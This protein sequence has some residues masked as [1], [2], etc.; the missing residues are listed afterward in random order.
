MF[1]FFRLQVFL[2]SSRFCFYGARTDFGW[3]WKS[4]DWEKQKE[5]AQADYIRWQTV[6]F[7]YPRVGKRSSPMHAPKILKLSL[8]RKKFKCQSKRAVWCTATKK[9]EQLVNCWGVTLV[10]CMSL[11]SNLL[12]ALRPPRTDSDCLK[13]TRRP[14]PSP[15]ECISISTLLC[16]Y[17]SWKLNIASPAQA[18]RHRA[19]RCYQELQAGLSPTKPANQLWTSWCEEETGG[20]NGLAT[21]FAGKS[22][23]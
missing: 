13:T 20:G 17:E 9:I 11:D 2:R 14:P 21:S 19:K 1:R 18:K 7:G 22:T 3:P 12:V 5:D 10:R 8:M 23:G 15:F 4:R 16:G 6:I